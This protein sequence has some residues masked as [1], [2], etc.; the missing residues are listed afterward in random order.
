MGRLNI[1]NIPPKEYS[2]SVNSG[3]KFPNNLAPPALTGEIIVP[4]RSA[5]LEPTFP[6]LEITTPVFNTVVLYSPIT[7]FAVEDF[8][9]PPSELP[10][11]NLPNIEECYLLT[12]N[13][14][15]ILITT[16]KESILFD[17]R[18]SINCIS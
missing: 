17:A 7:S 3:V 16:T 11:S 10:V 6:W 5:K 13:S 15:E 9:N 8:T 2:A 14:D 1:K 18:I 12:E 4:P